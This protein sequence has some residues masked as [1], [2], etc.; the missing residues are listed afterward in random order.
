MFNFV[1]T[2]PTLRCGRGRGRGRTTEESEDDVAVASVDT[3]M[4]QTA[5]HDCAPGPVSATRSL[6]GSQLGAAEVE[7]SGGV[8][9]REAANEREGGRRGVLENAH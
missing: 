1:G 8:D 6:S 4:S 9:D 2:A 7:A 3:E 5:V